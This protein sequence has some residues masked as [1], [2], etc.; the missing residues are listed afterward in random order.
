VKI[1]ITIADTS[2]SS[3]KGLRIFLRENERFECVAEILGTKSLPAILDEIPSEL[4]IIHYCCKVCFPISAINEIKIGCPKLKILVISHEKSLAEIRK[5]IDIGIANCIFSDCSEKEIIQAIETCMKST[6][7]F[8]EQIINALLE[9]VPDK[10]SIE[11]ILLTPRENEIIKLIAQ[12]LTGKKIAEKLFL[13]YHTISTHRKNIFQKL[14]I[15]STAEVV[16]YALRAGLISL[17]K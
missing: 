17:D 14:D 11:N 16:L 8:P 12:G 13:S 10:S 7:S 4:L 5:L 2:F 9:E 3:R 15:K 1:R 6:T